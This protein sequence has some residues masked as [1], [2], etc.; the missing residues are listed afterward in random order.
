MYIPESISV[1]Q[2]AIASSFIHTPQQHNKAGVTSLCPSLCRSVGWSS[3]I[4]R[5]LHFHAP[6]LGASVIK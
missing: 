2:T 5:A 3:Y 1:H 4:F 6:I